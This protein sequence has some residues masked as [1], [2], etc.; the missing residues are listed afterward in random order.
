MSAPLRSCHTTRVSLMPR[1]LMPRHTDV[2]PCHVIM[3]SSH[4]TSSPG[5]L[6]R[7]PL[8]D[9]P[10]VVMPFVDHPRFFRVLQDYAE[11]GR[12]LEGMC[13]CVRA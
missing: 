11:W 4:A 8:L 5:L 6:L 9:R 10:D 12:L 13:A 1:H 2:I 3:T 7:F